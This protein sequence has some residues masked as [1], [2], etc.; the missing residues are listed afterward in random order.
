MADEEN[1]EDAPAEGEE[2]A[3]E[4]PGEEGEEGGEE[5]PAE[6]EEAPAEGEEGAPEGEE[7]EGEGEIGEG[8][9]EGGEEIQPEEREGIISD[10]S[11]VFNELMNAGGQ[12]REAAAMIE[13][14][15]ASVKE[16]QT[17]EML[18]AEDAALL[19]S[20][21]DEL[22]AKLGEFGA[23]TIRIQTLLK[24]SHLTESQLCLLEGPRPGE[25]KE[26]F[27]LEIED[28]SLPKVIICGSEDHIPRIVVCEPTVKKEEPL[29]KCCCAKHPI[30]LG[31]IGGDTAG[32]KGDITMDSLL[33]QLSSLQQEMKL[34]TEENNF[35]SKKLSEITDKTRCSVCNKPKPLCRCDKPTAPPVCCG[36]KPVPPSC[37]P[38]KPKPVCNCPLPQKP[39]CLCCPPCQCSGPPSIPCCCGAS[40]TIPKGPVQS[41]CP[42]VPKPEPPCACCK[43]ADKKD[44][45]AAIAQMETRLRNMITDVSKMQCQLR[46][47]QQL[48]QKLE[49]EKS[50][51][52]PC[53]DELF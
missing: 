2:P 44:S 43:Q 53:F 41:T 18:S 27:D 42:V 39:P 30:L 9:E 6:G 17:K 47:L 49:E 37:C 10:E 7:G 12:A 25:E 35:L 38:P 26:T 1:P 52:C 22:M 5:A 31:G 29:L 32:Y 13:S 8:G 3:E 20:K 23:L 19:Q 11:D 24:L 15:K 14:L 48:R 28:E 46:E 50:D 34:I 4:A 51:L 40:A 36:S 33:K 21:Q 16:F 45:S